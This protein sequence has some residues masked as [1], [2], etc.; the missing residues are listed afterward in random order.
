LPNVH[1]AFS[2]LQ[3]ASRKQKENL[4]K[5]MLERLASLSKSEDDKTDP[6]ISMDATK[7]TKAQRYMKLSFLSSIVLQEERERE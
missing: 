4:V 1:G 6:A 2:T 3:Q 7:T 5:S